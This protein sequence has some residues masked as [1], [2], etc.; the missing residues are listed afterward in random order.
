MIYWS[1]IYNMC[2]QVEFSP[3]PHWGSLQHS[4]RPIAGYK[5]GEAKKGKGNEPTPMI[6]CSLLCIEETCT[7]ITS[8]R[9]PSR[10]VARF[11]PAV[12]HGVFPDSYCSRS[13]SSL[14]EWMTTESG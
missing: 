9:M 2:W 13:Q 7:L 11:S 6:T 5:G 1:E 8:S 14:V 10:L 12:K 4:F 3:R